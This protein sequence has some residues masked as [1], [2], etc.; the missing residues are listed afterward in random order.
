M[1]RLLQRA[2]LLAA[3]IAVGGLAALAWL[4][5]QGDEILR[6][7]LLRQLGAMFPDCDV[8]I[9]RAQF[10]LRG[11]VRV[12][13][14][15]LRLPEETEPALEIPELLVT[16]DR[17]A[18]AERQQLLL[19]EI[20][21]GQPT[22]HVT[23]R[24][25]GRWNWSNL[26]YVA[27]AGGGPLPDVVLQHAAVRL[28]IPESAAGAAQSFT[29]EDI[30][31][32]ARPASQRAYT[33]TGGARSDLTGR[34]TCQATVPLQVGAWQGQVTAESI[35]VDASMVRL[36]G[37]YWPELYA[38]WEQGERLLREKI[39]GLPAD[40]R[41]MTAR[42]P[43][44]VCTV[45]VTLSAAQTDPALPVQYR[46][47]VVLNGGRLTHAALPYPLRDLKGTIETNGDAIVVRELQGVNG[48]T[49]LTING[50]A[51]RSGTMNWQIVGNDLPL[52]EAT[53]LRMPPSLQ[54]QI[55]SL[56]L[57]G[58]CRGTVKLSKTP[59]TAWKIEATGS[60]SEATVRHE[61][62]PYL[63]QRVTGTGTW[64]N[65]VVEL[66]GQGMA[67][68][69]VVTM[70]GTIHNPGPVGDAVFEIRGDGVPIDD[71]VIRACPEGIRQAFQQMQFQ[72]M[73]DA[74]FIIMRPPGLNQKYHPQLWAKVKQ[75]RVQYVGFPY[76]V[77]NLSG[78]V[79]WV[80]D[81]VDFQQLSGT[82][83][84]AKLTGQG[85]F[86]LREGAKQ[87]TLGVEVKNGTLDRALYAAVGDSLRS[88]WDAFRPQGE[89][90]LTTRV[91]WV[92][93]AA[94]RI[95]I[96]TCTLRRGEFSL[97]EF[98]YLFHDVTGE[99]AYRDEQV[100]ILSCSARHDDTQ[101]RAVGTADC[102]TPWVVRLTEFHL[103][104]LAPNPAFR[105]A[106]FGPLK[107]VV[108][109]LNPTGLFSAHGPVTLY[110]PPAGSDVIRADWDLQ[111]HWVG[112]GINAGQRIS[113][114]HGRIDLAGSWD[115]RATEL[116]GRLDLDS[117]AI[118]G[119]HQLTR[120]RGPLQLK[121]AKLVF[122][123]AVMA[124]PQPA[125]AIGRVPAEERILGRAFGGDVTFDSLVDLSDEN[126][127]VYTLHAELNGANLERYA[128]EHLRG[129]SN[130]RGLVNGW[131][132]LNGRTWETARLEGRG[133]LQISPAALYELPVF[134][135][136]FQLPQFQP[137][138]RSAFRYAN[139]FFRLKNERF[140]FDSID[141]VGNTIGLR[142]R[143][144]IRF[145]GAL[146][147]DFYSMQ[148]RNPIAIP[149]LREI[150]GVV[151]QMSQ[152]WLAVEVRGTMSVPVARVVP[153]PVFDAAMKEF[154]APFE[155]R[156]A[157]PQPPTP[158]F[159]P[160]LRQGEGDTPPR[161]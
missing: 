106:L 96:P 94:P 33:V 73:A 2:L 32:T 108:E 12:T 104:D 69:S 36:I 110:G 80:G 44:V 9:V 43:G 48:R 71:A 117:L 60:L 46:G 151:N 29:I 8:T 161:R 107:K 113:D 1:F 27:Q 21:I 159:G 15:A 141:L 114:I 154:L 40:P 3:L 100:T 19:E 142:G 26:R 90:D 68:E 150:V 149:G 42:D 47:A 77:R 4:S 125:D 105:R 57:T 5:V 72:G 134:L 82:H 93:G 86:L 139:F 144:S 55:A 89:F 31:L 83:D 34:V 52:D 156:G 22:I 143:G 20:R 75:A 128:Q 121:D 13:S 92:P 76:E 153:F 25:D 6:Q 111:T 91:A 74:R 98:P 122:G 10:D 41:P 140:L 152:G 39:P 99:F 155:R 11:R 70:S 123:S 81:I 7:E 129:H 145:D 115:G 87:L 131:L 37:R 157:G 126:E 63:V 119:N 61:R 84:D 23:Q 160:P 56:A 51:D 79:T 101:I 49:T 30:A 38:Q 130:V 54:R 18:L 53:V 146:A 103:D 112:C 127:P 147:L 62:F 136:I 45:Q 135:Q 148:P 118:F 67:G 137:V 97:R 65:D 14:L 95:E 120:I 109:A 58:L 28:Q 132:D 138:E 50:R 85:R 64:I 16:L 133:Q 78:L 158:T 116:A 35:Q 66:R 124:R 102:V 59:E 88:V 24:G 17:T